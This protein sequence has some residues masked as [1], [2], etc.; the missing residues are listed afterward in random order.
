MATLARQCNSSLLAL[1]HTVRFV[2]ASEANSVSEGFL[3]SRI[4]QPFTWFTQKRGRF[5][6]PLDN[7]EGSLWKSNKL[8]GKF[9]EKDTHSVSS[10]CQSVC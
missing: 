3:G 2:L 5:L 8:V 1:T 10:C 6:I 4:L 9:Q 7:L